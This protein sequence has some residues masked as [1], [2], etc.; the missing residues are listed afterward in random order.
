MIYF[1][2]IVNFFFNP[3]T[4]AFKMF[5]IYLESSHGKPIN[6]GTVKASGTGWLDGMSTMTNIGTNGAWSCTTNYSSAKIFVDG[7]FIGI[8]SHG[9]KIVL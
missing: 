3:N 7:K 6:S 4:G 9:A 2:Q 1:H 5:T 8:F